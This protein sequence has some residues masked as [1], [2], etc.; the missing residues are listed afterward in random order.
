VASQLESA[1]RLEAEVSAAFRGV[2]QA[3]RQNEL[4][5]STSARALDAR[6]AGSKK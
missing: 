1:D 3:E 5:K 2:G 4:S 6:R